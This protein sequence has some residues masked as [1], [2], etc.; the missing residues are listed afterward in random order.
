MAT[1]AYL[2]CAGRLASQL[3]ED[4]NR[5]LRRLLKYTMTYIQNVFS[6]PRLL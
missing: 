1:L 4:G 6:G 3:A 2:V 5:L